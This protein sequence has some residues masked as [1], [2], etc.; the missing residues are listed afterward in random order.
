M[1][2]SGLEWLWRLSHDPHRLAGRYLLRDM[3]FLVR[4]VI[5]AVTGAGDAAAR[6]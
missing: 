3:P 2:R 4:S 1:R 5:R 6:A